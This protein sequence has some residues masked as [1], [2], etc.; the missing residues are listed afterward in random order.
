METSVFKSQTRNAG[1]IQT[2]GRDLKY[3]NKLS[4]VATVQRESIH[5][6]LYSIRKSRH[7]ISDLDLNQPSSKEP[8]K[9]EF[10][11]NS[12]QQFKN[13]SKSSES[14]S[15]SDS[16]S[17]KSDNKVEVYPMQNIEDDR[18]VV[19][20]DEDYFNK[21]QQD[22][23][24]FIREPAPIGQLVKCK[25]I[26]VKS[27]FS[28]YYFYLEYPDGNK[29]LLMQTSRKKTNLNI[30]FWINVWYYQNPPLQVRFGRLVSNLSRNTFMLIGDLNSQNTEQTENSNCKKYLDLDYVHK[31]Y[32]KPKPKEL[33]VEILL[34]SNSMDTITTQENSI[35]KMFKKQVT[36]RMQLTTRKPIFDSKLKKYKLDFKGRVKM[37]SSNNL[38]LIDDSENVLFQ[39]GK[40]KKNVYNC[41]FSY[42]VNAFQ[43]FSIAVSCLA[44]K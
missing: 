17:E 29:L 26:V 41:D 11:S 21:M 14:E 33:N 10:I 43:A 42:P 19:Q 30:F 4:E 20:I 18:K 36:K 35:E 23:I 44:R 25:V 2:S 39:L 9:S 27:V 13:T 34:P 37:A 15:D 22:M 16:D 38:Q 5:D 40:F 32:G 31:F 6:D 3:Y 24:Q 8:A 12:V 28:E 1:T 7:K